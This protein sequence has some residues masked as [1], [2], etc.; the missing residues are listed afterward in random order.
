MDE[1]YSRVKNVK[2]SNGIGIAGFVLSI[3]S[4]VVSFTS[5]FSVIFW[6]LGII[7]SIIG[8]FQKP[9]GFAIAGTIISAV[10]GLLFILMIVFAFWAMNAIK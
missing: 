6:I 1:N 10:S 8:L 3:V 9:K 5:L 2:V 7:F 4:V